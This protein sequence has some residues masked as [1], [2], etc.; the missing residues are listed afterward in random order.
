MFYTLTLGYRGGPRRVRPQRGKPGNY[1]RQIRN[2]RNSRQHLRACFWRGGERPRHRPRS[3]TAGLAARANRAISAG[4]VPK[5]RRCSR[6]SSFRG[7]HITHTARNRSPTSIPAHRS[8]AAQL[9]SILLPRRT[10]AGISTNTFFRGSTVP[11]G[12]APCQPCLR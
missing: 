12:G 4:A 6:G 5:R 7:P 2:Q 8:T 9:W 1:G 3:H 10:T 11:L